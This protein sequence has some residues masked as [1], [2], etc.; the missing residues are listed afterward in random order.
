MTA[1]D[2]HPTPDELAAMAFVDGEL[3]PQERGS[4]EARLAEQPRLAR[5]VAELQRLAVLARSVAPLEPKDHE[6]QRLSADPVHRA[7]M[8]LGGGLLV[9]GALAAL[10]LG[11][12]ALASSPSIPLGVRLSLLGLG[13]GALCL[14]LTTLRARLRTLPYDPYTKVQR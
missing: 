2:R 14:F 5:E 3:D 1:Q 8:G 6:W 7:G 11:G 4:F 13:L 10:G 12:Y 9:F